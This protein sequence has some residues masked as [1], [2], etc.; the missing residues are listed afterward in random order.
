LHSPCILFLD[1]LD[2]VAPDRSHGGDDPLTREIVGQ[3]LQEID[4][5]QSYSEHVFLVGATNRPRAVD[6]AILSRFTERVVVPLP[7]RES[8]IRLLSIFLAGKK[9]DFPL[10]NGAVLLSDISQGKELSGRDLK[11]WVA[12]A[13]QRALLRAIEEGG[14]EKY[15]ITLDD[16]LPLSAGFAHLASKNCQ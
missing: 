14:P 8:R 4:G 13:E 7:D 1:E 2:I 15:V 12:A 11:S 9:L 3:L 6:A 16:F 5:I 10:Q